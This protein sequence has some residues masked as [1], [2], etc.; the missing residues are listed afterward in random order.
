[1]KGFWGSESVDS[2]TY[3]WSK[4]TSYIK[5]P[6]IEAISPLTLSLCIGGLRPPGVRPPRASIKVN[7]HTLAEFITSKGME[8]YEFAVNRWMLEPGDLVV[9]IE[10]DTF[11]PGGGDLRELGVIV[12]W[13]KIETQ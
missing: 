9:E 12:D 4:G 5:F 10:S 6:Q 2:L 8:I 1:V 13:I 7:G 3:R 11:V